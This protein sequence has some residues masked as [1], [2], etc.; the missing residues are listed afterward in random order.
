MLES[1]AK[2]IFYGTGWCPGCW[3]ARTKI[4]YKWVDTSFFSEDGV[5]TIFWILATATVL[6]SNGPP[7]LGANSAPHGTLR[8]PPQPRRGRA[9]CCPLLRANSLFTLSPCAVNCV[10]GGDLS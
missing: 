3:H 5:P 6:L 8:P 7:W 10:L 4:P 1:Q 2:I 9:C